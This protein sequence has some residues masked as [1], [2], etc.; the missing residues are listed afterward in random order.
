MALKQLSTLT[1]YLVV[2]Q[3]LQVI[4]S[5]QHYLSLR[6]EDLTSMRL[7]LAHLTRLGARA[8]K[9]APPARRARFLCCLRREHGARRAAEGSRWAALPSPSSTTPP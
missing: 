2:A 4:S 6:L 7:F 8:A 3:Q 9:P 5:G 1:F